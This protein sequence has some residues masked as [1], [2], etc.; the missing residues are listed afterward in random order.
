MD[1]VDFYGFILRY[2]MKP[3]MG[4]EI[5]TYTWMVEFFMGSIRNSKYTVRPM[6]IRHGFSRPRHCRH[7]T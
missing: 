6:V 4:L 2:F 1:A 5:F 7:E 3:S